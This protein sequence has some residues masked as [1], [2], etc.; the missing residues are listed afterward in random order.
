M[1]MLFEPMIKDT[2]SGTPKGQQGWFAFWRSGSNVTTPNAF[3][4]L[5]YA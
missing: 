5:T 3:R 4:A 2:T 1:S